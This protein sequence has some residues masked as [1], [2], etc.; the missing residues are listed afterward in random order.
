MGKGVTD[1]GILQIVHA[2]FS[3]YI[4]HFTFYTLLAPSALKWIGEGQDCQLPTN[5]QEI[6]MDRS[7]LGFWLARLEF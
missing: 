6:A 1:V 4:L 7:L 5:S 3:L 2:I